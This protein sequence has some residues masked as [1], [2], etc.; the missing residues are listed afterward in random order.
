[1][2][3]VGLLLIAVG[4][5]SVCGG[6]FDWDFFLNSRKAQFYV[7]IFGR[8]GARIFYVILGI[9]FAVLGTMMALGV[10]KDAS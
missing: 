5:F 4:L 10:L 9:A 8:T 1:M 6:A 7:S 3:P 2:N